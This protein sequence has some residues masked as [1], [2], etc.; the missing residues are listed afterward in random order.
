ML[1][2]DLL[3]RFNLFKQPHEF[4][5]KDR[6]I[7]NAILNESIAQSEMTEFADS[8]SQKNDHSQKNIYREVESVEFENI[9]EIKS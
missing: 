8:N 1:I 9:S 2:K 5:E 4:I 7:A 6:A 3:A